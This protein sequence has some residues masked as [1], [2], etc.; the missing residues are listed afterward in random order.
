[1]GSL[2]PLVALLVV[3][4]AGLTMGVV[5]VGAEAAESARARTAADATALAGAGGG[6]SMANKV[7]ADNGAR[8]ISLVTDGDETEV[9]IKLGETTARARAV[10][11]T[12]PWSSSGSRGLHPEL[13]KALIKAGSLLGV[14]VP[15][16]SGWRSRGEQQRLYDQRASSPYPVAKPGSSRHEQGLAID[17]PLGFVAR[18]AS[19]AQEVGLCRPVAKADPIHFEL[20][21]LT[22]TQ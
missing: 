11:E 7:A 15:I 19:V 2:T 3:V 5:R 17:V 10:A 8:M 22:P 1:M 21:S 12:T 4:G 18:L 16:T 9:V 13:R 20:C 6:R 14:P